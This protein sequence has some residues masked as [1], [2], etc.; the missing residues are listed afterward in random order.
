M[1][2]PVPCNQGILYLKEYGR[3]LTV[4]FAGKVII[5]INEDPRKPPEYIK[6]VPSGH[7]AISFR[8]MTP[9]VREVSNDLSRP[10]KQQVAGE[11]CDDQ[12]LYAKF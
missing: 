6:T 1:I 4:L 3:V 12:P 11:N 7:P 8:A 5:T 10:Q 2:V 9:S